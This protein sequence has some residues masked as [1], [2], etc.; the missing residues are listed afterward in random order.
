MD[1]NKNAAFMIA[2]EDLLQQLAKEHE[3]SIRVSVREAKN[4]MWL[5]LVPSDDEAKQQFEM[6]TWKFGYPAD[7]WMKKF[8]AQGTTYQI[9]GVKPTA[10]KNCFRIKR[11][12]DGKEFVCGKGFVNSGLD[13]HN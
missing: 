7:W 1:K 6:Y 5:E 8:I 11:L 4:G 10:E 2:A 13:V 3:V 12:T 9:V